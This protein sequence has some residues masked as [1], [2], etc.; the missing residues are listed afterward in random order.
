MLPFATFAY[1]RPLPLGWLETLNLLIAFRGAP[2]ML[3]R[4][5]RR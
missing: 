1:T 5:S 4:H 3:A 2:L